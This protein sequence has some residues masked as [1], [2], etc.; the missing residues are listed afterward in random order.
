MKTFLFGCACAFLLAGC[1]SFRLEQQ[2]S[3]SDDEG[4]G[5]LFVEYGIMTKAYTYTVVSPVNG[6]PLECTDN[7]VAKVTLPYDYQSEMITDAQTGQKLVKITKNPSRGE[8]VSMYSCQNLINA[9]KMYS[10]RDNKWKYVTD[11]LHCRLYLFVPESGDYWH[12]YSGNCF[13]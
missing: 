13:E 1:S 12:V 7:K 5:V 11:G 6:A 2:F 8:Q 3:F 9:G 10:T 4:E